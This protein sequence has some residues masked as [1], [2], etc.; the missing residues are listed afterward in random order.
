LAVV[1]FEFEA[2]LGEVIRFRI[3]NLVRSYIVVLSDVD[4]N[5]GSRESSY[6]LGLEL[7]TTSSL[8]A[9]LSLGVS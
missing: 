1:D 7:S 9:V 2:Q 5:V 8:R 3:M 4:D 6:L